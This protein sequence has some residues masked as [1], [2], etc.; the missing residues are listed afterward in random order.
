MSDATGP[1]S[2]LEAPL[3][4]ERG[5]NREN[6]KRRMVKKAEDAL[7][8]SIS[9]LK[10]LEDKLEIDQA[11]V[12]SANEKNAEKRA[13]AATASAQKVSDQKRVVD[14]CKKA[15]ERRQLDASQA[16]NE[17]LEKELKKSASRT[18]SAPI[19]NEGVV[20]LVTIRLSM[21]DER[22]ARERLAEKR[23]MQHELNVMRVL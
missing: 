21:Q 1:E 10:K 13:L 23:R 6:L 8:Q 20:A 14:A 3:A 18:K 22:Y 5:P 16:E 2:A 15:V 7:V 4:V 17:A 19:S 12:D 11:N 9:K